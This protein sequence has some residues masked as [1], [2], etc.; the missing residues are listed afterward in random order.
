MYAIIARCTVVAADCMHIMVGVATNHFAIFVTNRETR[1]N[2]A[3]VIGAHNVASLLLT[4]HDDILMTSLCL[5]H[6]HRLIEVD[7]AG[8]PQ[9]TC[10]THITSLCDVLVR[11][12][13]ICRVLCPK[14]FNL[15]PVYMFVIT[16]LALAWCVIAADVEIA[17]GADTTLPTPV[18][19]M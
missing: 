1:C 7:T 3:H 8:W 19:N 6:R 17:F 15:A 18:S 12:I 5:R 4:H 14:C 16:I 10:D 11:C 13:H 9:R 2:T